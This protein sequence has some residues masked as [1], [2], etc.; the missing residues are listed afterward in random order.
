MRA[1]EFGSA[2]LRLKEAEEALARA[3][4]ANQRAQQARDIESQSAAERASEA[5]QAEVRISQPALNCQDLIVTDN[6]F[7]AL[8]FTITAPRVE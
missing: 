6:G 4:A 7:D 5:R 2:Q 1:A 3:G 8:N